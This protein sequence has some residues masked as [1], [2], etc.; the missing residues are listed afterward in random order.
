M[1]ALAR[2]FESDP[3]ER[4]IWL[5][6]FSEEIPD[7]RPETWDKKLAKGVTFSATPEDPEAIRKKLGIE[8]HHKVLVIPVL[9]GSWSRIHKNSMGADFSRAALENHP[10]ERKVL[11]DARDLPFKT[12]EFDHVVSYELTPLSTGLSDPASILKALKELLRVGKQ[13]H[14]IQRM[15]GDR[16]VWT[17]PIIT[18]YLHELG[19]EHKIVDL[20]EHTTPQYFFYNPEKDR[21][22][23]LTISARDAHKLLDKMEQDIRTMERAV[24]HFKRGEIQKGTEE[25]VRNGSVALQ[26]AF[27][28]QYF[29]RRI[30]RSTARQMKTEFRSRFLGRHP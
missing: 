10:N 9:D 5:R 18:R 30:F 23:S 22:V 13:V 24:E 11:A 26:R 7:S 19:I 8:D 2:K 4:D 27:F 14:I 3:F 16:L 1:I 25:I 28:E 29:L 6:S 21:V 15:H 12:G 20:S 17:E